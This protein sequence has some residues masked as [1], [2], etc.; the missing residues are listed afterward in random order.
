MSSHASSQTSCCQEPQSVWQTRALTWL[1]PS[2]FNAGHQTLNEFASEGW[3]HCKFME[4]SS[5]FQCLMNM[6]QTPEGFLQNILQSLKIQTISNTAV[7][8]CPSVCGWQIVP[9]R[10]L[11]KL[12]QEK[13]KHQLVDHLCSWRCQHVDYK[14]VFTW[15]HILR[16]YIVY[17]VLKQPEP[18]SWKWPHWSKV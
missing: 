4:N 10:K 12:H 13:K 16:N 7:A 15:C 5:N 17:D 1:L 9:M 14:I 3:N 11:D 6:F 8:V 2:D 18:N